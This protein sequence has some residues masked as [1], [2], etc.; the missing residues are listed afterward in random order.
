MSW[1]FT[2]M[3]LKAVKGRRLNLRTL[4]NWAQ[5]WASIRL[6]L[7]DNIQFYSVVSIQF[8]N[9]FPLCVA[10][11][12][13]LWF[14][15]YIPAIWFTFGYLIEKKEKKRMKEKVNKEKSNETNEWM[16]QMF[17][18]KLETLEKNYYPNKLWKWSNKL[19]S[20]L[21]QVWTI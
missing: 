10:L 19:I 2:R 12:P 6:T 15:Y 20:F 16:K 7:S 17:F 5:K 4:Q 1:V 3:F 21:L 9:I 13:C 11:N 14:V 18:I 8:A